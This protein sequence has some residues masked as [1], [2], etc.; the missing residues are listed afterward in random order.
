MATVNVDLEVKMVSEMPDGLNAPFFVLEVKRSRLENDID[1][2]LEGLNGMD[3]S[4][5]IHIVFH[6]IHKTKNVL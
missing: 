2:A 3:I 5:F 4:K 6:D 1:I